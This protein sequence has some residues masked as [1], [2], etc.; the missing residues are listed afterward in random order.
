ME[1][2][3]ESCCPVIL[4]KW[5]LS[6]HLGICFWISEPVLV[7]TIVFRVWVL[8]LQPIYAMYALGSWLGPS[9]EIPLYAKTCSVS[10]LNMGLKLELNLL[11]QLVF[12]LLCSFLTCVEYELDTFGATSDE[13]CLMAI[14]LNPGFINVSQK[15][16]V[17]TSIEIRRITKDLCLNCTEN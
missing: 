16:W 6:R 1:L 10:R 14:Y 7:Q 3:V 9:D 8:D 5:P 2:F 12:I 11:K 15:T 4:H 13:I 17:S